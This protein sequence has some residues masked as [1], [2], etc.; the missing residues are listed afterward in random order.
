[1]LARNNGK[2][3]RAG[4]ECLTGR[5]TPENKGRPP[6]FGALDGSHSLETGCSPYA[7]RLSGKC[8]CPALS[9]DFA[10][11]RFGHVNAANQACDR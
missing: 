10:R 7:T 3:P 5:P 6:A 9:H 4:R 11:N 1:M 8:R 2:F